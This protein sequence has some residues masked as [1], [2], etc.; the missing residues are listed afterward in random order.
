LGDAVLPA[1]KRYRVGEVSVLS[2]PDFVFSASGDLGLPLVA[3]ILSS[4][5]AKPPIFGQ[6]LL[7]RL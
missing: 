5:D 3:L 7:L 2:R 4:K 6:N 1:N